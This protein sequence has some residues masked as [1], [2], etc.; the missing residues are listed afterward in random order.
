[1]ISIYLLGCI[2]TFIL[3]MFMNYLIYKGGNDIYVGEVLLTIL[4]TLTSWLGL[5][6]IILSFIEISLKSKRVVIKRPTSSR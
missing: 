6:F 1:M 5:I 4:L 3:C 2:V